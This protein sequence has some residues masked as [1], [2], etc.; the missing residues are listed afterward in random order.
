MTTTMTSMAEII[1]VGGWGLR[2]LGFSFG[3][4]ERAVRLLAW[5]E[6][7]LGSSLRCVRLAEAKI[8]QSYT[9]PKLSQV[10]H[11]DG[12][13]ELQA[14]GRHLLEIGP[15][16]AD[17]ITADT[18]RSAKG[19]LSLCGSIGAE[20]GPAL[21][22]VLSHRM[23]TGVLVYS[24]EAGARSDAMWLYFAPDLVSVPMHFDGQEQVAAAPV[25]VGLSEPDRQ[26]LAD[27]LAG[28]TQRMEKCAD[29]YLGFIAWQGVD[30]LVSD[31]HT[32]LSA[33]VRA[34]WA[35]GIESS[36]E[37]IRYLYELEMRTWAPTSERSRSQAG[38]G[39]F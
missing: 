7:A 38:Y 5:T 8:T 32:N 39:K 29:S 12:F 10:I 3:V 26:W 37:D 16:A 2:G 17:L 13:R 31:D 14:H 25:A 36:I 30:Q 9:A 6:A 28:H 19:R 24:K 23:L 34:A 22:S 27:E 33:R 4:A 11:S 21:A 35:N 20:F 18:R 1:R 15:P